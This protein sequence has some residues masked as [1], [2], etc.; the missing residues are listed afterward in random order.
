MEG[1]RKAVFSERYLAIFCMEEQTVYLNFVVDCR[2]DN[3]ELLENI[4]ILINFLRLA[5]A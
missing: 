5:Q 3:R 2:R 4:K 1:Y